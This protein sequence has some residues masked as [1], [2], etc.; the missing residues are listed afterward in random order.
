MELGAAISRIQDFIG[1]RYQAEVV[2]ALIEAVRAGEVANGIVRQM[3]E[4][5]A[6]EAAHP[7]ALL[8]R[9]VA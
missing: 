5:R 3:A 9:L 7:E 8:D 6:A 1:T 4:K 2:Q